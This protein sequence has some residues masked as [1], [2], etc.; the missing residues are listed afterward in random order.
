[1]QVCTGFSLEIKKGGPTNSLKWHLEKQH[2]DEEE[3]KQ[4]FRDGATKKR[5]AEEEE[6]TPKRQRLA[7]PSTPKSGSS[8][9]QP[10][11]LDFGKHI[12]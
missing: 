2:A 7:P 6:S 3:V 1:L 12:I 9:K 4:F 11:I 5:A 10:N 8:L